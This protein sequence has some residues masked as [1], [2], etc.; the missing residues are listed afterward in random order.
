METGKGLK[1]ATTKEECK[2]MIQPLKEEDGSNIT[3]R[4]R[5]LERFAEFYER[6][7]EDAVQNIAKVETEEVPSILTSEV[8]RPLSQM[9]SRK[10]PGGDQVVAEII[11]AGGEIA[12]WTIQ[13][14]F[15][16]ALRTETVPKVWKNAII[17]LNIK[18]GRH[19]RPC[20]LQTYQPTLTYLQIIHESSEKHSEAFSMNIN[21]QS[22]H[23]TGEDS[24]Q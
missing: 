20:Q 19:E 24:P 14:L 22:K 23:R 21:R 6:L 13:D 8:E 5:I 3:N 16:A 7:Y 11:K 1:N 17:T 15:N 2:V 12:L 9:K 4:E 18:E 10:A